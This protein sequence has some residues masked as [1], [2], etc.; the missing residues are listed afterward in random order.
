MADQFAG[1]G[2]ASRTAAAQGQPGL[3]D[4]L[5]QL[6]GAALNQYQTDPSTRTTVDMLT[7]GMPLGAWVKQLKLPGGN[8]SRIMAGPGKTPSAG[9][10]TLSILYDLIKDRARILGMNRQGPSMS[11]SEGRQ[12]GGDVANFFRKQGAREVVADVTPWH[13]R[14]LRLNPEPDPKTGA[15]T[16]S[17]MLDP[18][19]G[20]RIY[21]RMLGVP[22]IENDPTSNP[23]STYTFPLYP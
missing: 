11:F 13:P 7:A 5:G 21:S 8:F 20:A 14:T 17:K 3:G 1:P 15:R 10:P 9:G 19:T 16:Y 2:R 4:L 18:K 12:T 6:T 23:Y 22:A